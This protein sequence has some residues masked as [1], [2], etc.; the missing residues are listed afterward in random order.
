VL[1]V[2]RVAGTLLLLAHAG[3]MWTDYRWTPTYAR[4]DVPP[5]VRS[6]PGGY[7]SWSFW[8]AGEHGGK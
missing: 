7:R 1:N 2:V 4:A 3:M 6:S 5:S 8:H